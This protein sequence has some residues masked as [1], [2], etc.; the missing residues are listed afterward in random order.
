MRGATDFD[1]LLYASERPVLRPNVSDF[2]P[3]SKWIGAKLNIRDSLLPENNPVKDLTVGQISKL[4]KSKGL[5]S[6]D[7][8]SVRPNSWHLT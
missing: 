7:G 4:S 6:L 8:C 2:L 1:H 3:Y 5:A